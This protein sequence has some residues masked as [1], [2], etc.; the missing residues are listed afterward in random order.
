MLGK[1]LHAGIEER[2]SCYLDLI[3]GL[4]GI[5]YAPVENVHAVI[6]LLPQKYQIGYFI[7]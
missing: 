5:F 3:L 1:G 6:S 2:G 4:D 7:D